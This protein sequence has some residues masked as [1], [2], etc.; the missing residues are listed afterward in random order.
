MVLRV[1]GHDGQAAGDAVEQVAGRALVERAAGVDE[2]Q[3]VAHL[4]ELAEVV[5][6]HQDGAAGAGQAGR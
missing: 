3:P 5:G 1:L 2:H 4:L 6:R